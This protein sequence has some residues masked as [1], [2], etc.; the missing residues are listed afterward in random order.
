MFTAGVFIEVQ[1]SK[2]LAV[3][4]MHVRSHEV[5]AQHSMVWMWLHTLHRLPGTWSC[6]ILWSLSHHRRMQYLEFN[7]CSHPRFIETLC[8]TLVFS[9]FSKAGLVVFVAWEYPSSVLQLAALFFEEGATFLS[10][11]VGTASGLSILCVLI[12]NLAAIRL[13]SMIQFFVKWSLQRWKVAVGSLSIHMRPSLS[14]SHLLVLQ[15]S[16]IGCTEVAY[17]T[18]NP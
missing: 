7:S 16:E 1:A 10:K 14:P 8:Y 11:I 17:E 12:S 15:N 5:P 9:C 18:C 6:L 2:L 3:D 13:V 4:N